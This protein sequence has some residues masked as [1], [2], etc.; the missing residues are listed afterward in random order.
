[1]VDAGTFRE[2]LFY[3]LNIVPVKLPSLRERK[4]DI[5]LLLKHL[6]LQL[7][8]QHQLE[9]PRFHKEAM[10]LINHHAW[11][12][13]VREL[14]NFCERMLIFFSGRE[15]L[16]SNLPLEVKQAGTASID[17]IFTLPD[18]GISLVSLEQQ[19]IKQALEKTKG[20]QTRA[21]RLLD[22]SRDA[23]LYRMK[24]HQIV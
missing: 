13:N 9:A 7:S 3:R 1:M 21:A 17:N 20:N 5:P 4:S 23:L 19:L 12:G 18:S 2:D 15:V 22:I 16:A 10:D 8:A 11:P 14:K 6:T 24:K